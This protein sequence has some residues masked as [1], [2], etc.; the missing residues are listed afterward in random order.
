MNRNELIAAVAAS[1]DLS[2]AKA[3]E[4]IDAVFASIG[5]SLVGGD[6]VRIAGFGTFSTVHRAASRGRN[7][8]TNEII[9]IAASR[10]PKFKASKVLKD[11][12]NG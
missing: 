12:V 5:G 10:Q 1:A 8:R 7:P 3:G 11:A 6:D 4:A 9:E 2:K